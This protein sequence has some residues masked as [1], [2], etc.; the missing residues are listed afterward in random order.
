MTP[1]EVNKHNQLLYK[2]RNIMLFICGLMIIGNILFGIVALSKQERIVI[3]PHLKEEVSVEGSDGFSGSYLEQM[4]LFYV[5]MLLDL[6]ADNIDYKSTVLLKHVDWGSYHSFIDYYK[7][8]KAKYKK[9]GLAT[10]FDVSGFKILNKGKEVEVRGVL[11]SSF[12]TGSMN[13][14]TVTYIIG[15]SKSHGKLLVKT[16]NEKVKEK[17]E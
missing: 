15:Y 9:Y 3:V 2:Q 13:Q 8:E 11:S 12:G 17:N 7:E 1:L 5:D 6:T 10:K 16:F 4:T 14:K